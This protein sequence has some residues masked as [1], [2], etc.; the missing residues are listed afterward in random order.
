MWANISLYQ[1]AL[2]VLLSFA[3]GWLAHRY[4]ALSLSGSIA[5]FVLGAAIFGIGGWGWAAILLT[6]FLTSS[7][8]SRAFSQQK[9]AL[10][11][12]IEKGAKRDGE[13]VLANGGIALLCVL[14]SAFY[15]HSSLPF[16]AAS[17]SLAAANA[18]TWATELG[19]L[20][21]KPPRLI[22]N[23]QVVERGVSGGVSGL[24]LLAS[25]AGSALV[26]LVGMF[27]VPAKLPFFGVI[28][29]SGVLGSLIDSLLGA[30]VQTVYYCP[31]CEKETEK[32]PL[33]NCGERT[34]FR[35]GWKWINNDLV[36]FA[37]TL[38][39]ALISICL[40]LI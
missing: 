3:I 11:S 7:L 4:G 24:G 17:A 13:Q 22:T 26:A 15:P 27:F 2:G 19:V 14:F 33:H 38:S 36:N 6:F 31:R 28:W 35:R 8:L 1:I 32:H 39:A 20:A 9:I 25:I 5:A 29:L 34:I 21:I 18:D 12:Q 37:C 23:W 40:W 30:S 10:E 16:L